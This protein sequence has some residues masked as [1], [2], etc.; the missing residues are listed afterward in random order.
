MNVVKCRIK[1][2][3]ISIRSNLR[4]QTYFW[5]P[6]ICERSKAILEINV[7][8]NKAFHDLTASHLLALWEGAVA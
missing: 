2:K 7:A 8:F 5:H 6:E 4:M 3:Y 1:L